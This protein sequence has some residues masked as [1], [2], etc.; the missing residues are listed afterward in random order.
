MASHCFIN[1]A[2]YIGREFNSAYVKIVKS[3]PVDIAAVRY[4][5]FRPCVII[6]RV[7][8]YIQ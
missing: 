7:V 8:I 3:I 4:R 5:G 2:L 6:L 1:I